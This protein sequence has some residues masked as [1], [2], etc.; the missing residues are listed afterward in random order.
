MGYVDETNEAADRILSE[1]SSKAGGG[2]VAA[3]GLGAAARF[4]ARSRD[5]SRDRFLEL[6]EK[7][8]DHFNKCQ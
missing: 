7:A 3:L 1:L 4:C 8:Y 6:A 2:L 5:F